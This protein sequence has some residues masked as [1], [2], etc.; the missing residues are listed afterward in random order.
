M[1]KVK[2]ISGQ[3]RY[4]KTTA[5]AI[6]PK[7]TNRAMEKTTEKIIVV[8]ASTG[9]TEAL[10]ILFEISQWI[11][12]EWL[13]FNICLKIFPRHLPNALILFVSQLSKKPATTTLS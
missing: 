8:G 9:G 1:V 4:E 10:R 5:D 6:L 11:A 12:R 13:K 2:K 3:K 7:P